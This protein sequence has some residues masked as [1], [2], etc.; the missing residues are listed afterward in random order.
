MMPHYS[1]Q[2]ILFLCGVAML[3]RFGWTVAKLFFYGVC[4]F[5]VIQVVW[6]ILR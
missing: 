5:V 4:V 3:V 6:G 2:F 1:M